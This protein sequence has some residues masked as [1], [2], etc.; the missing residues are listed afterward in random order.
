MRV[1]ETWTCQA[2]LKRLI[3]ALCAVECG[4]A[5][6][7]DLLLP[8]VPVSMECRRE[9]VEDCGGG[10]KTFQPQRLSL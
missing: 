8:Q 10:M 6:L 2:D 9:N 1:T 5:G 4:Y 3:D 7:P